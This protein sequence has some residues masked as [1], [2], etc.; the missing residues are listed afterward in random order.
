MVVITGPNTGGKTVALKT[1]GLLA[2]MAQSGM[3]IPAHIHFGLWG[4]GYPFQYAGEVRFQGDPFLS[5]QDLDRVTAE[6]KFAD[7]VPIQK[8]ANGVW[9]ARFNLRA[10]K[11]SNFPGE[12]PDYY[13]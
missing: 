4:T 9:H 8:D 2:L 6:G 3:H 13:K 11:L 12:L 1:V 7:V 5:Q 10:S